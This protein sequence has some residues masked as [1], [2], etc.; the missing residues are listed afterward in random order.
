MLFALLLAVAA[1]VRADL[2][3]AA[4]P[5]THHLTPAAT[6]FRV[7]TYRAHPCLAHIIDHE[8]G[9]WDPTIDYGGGHGDVEQSY[10]LVQAD[11]G[12]KMAS[13]GRDWRTSRATQLRWALAYARSR[14]GSE[15]GAWN[16]W[17][18]H[19]YW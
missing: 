18:A 6:L 17:H 7:E 4:P 5:T 11:P 10:G 1:P 8:D 13:T 9:T 19:W 3:K 2:A 16:F 14:Y 12:T 15:C